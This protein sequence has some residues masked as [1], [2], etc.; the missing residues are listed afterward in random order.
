MT[1]TP[2][3]APGCGL[4]AVTRG[5][6]ETHYRR[7]LHTGR[8]GYRDATAAREHVRALRRLGWPYIPIAEAAG[9]S[10]WVP[11]QL[12][13]GGVRRILGESEKAILSIRL[14]PYDSHRGVDGTGTF[15]RWD[16]LQWMGWPAVEIARRVGVRP[17]SIPSMR[18]RGDQ[19]SYRVAHAMAEVYEELSHVPG[20]SEGSATKARR[21]GWAPP[22]AWDEDTID[23][24]TARP[25]GVRRSA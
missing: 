17:Y 2:C 8:Y 11:H 13:V 22:A 16:A 18:S 23:D 24:P 12:D 7:R 25:T 1:A 3:N 10:N 6:C 4:P 5:Y 15:R 20:P 21:K 9:T 14:V 19:V